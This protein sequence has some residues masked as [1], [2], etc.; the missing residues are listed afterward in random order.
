V[1]REAAPLQPHTSKVIIHVAEGMLIFEALLSCVITFSAVTALLL[2][3]RVFNWL[4]LTEDSFL[5]SIMLYVIVIPLA[6]LS[7]HWLIRRSRRAVI[8][9]IP[10]TVGVAAYWLEAV[11]TGAV[12][13]ATIVWAPAIFWSVLYLFPGIV[14]CLLWKRNELQRVSMSK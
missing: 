3:A 11:G 5:S 7:A 14:L 9:V 1:Q 12:L 2:S 6:L 8:G 13:K 4:N 10:S